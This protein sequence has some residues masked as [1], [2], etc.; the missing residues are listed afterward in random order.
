MNFFSKKKAPKKT[1]ETYDERSQKVLEGDDKEAE[2]MAE[3][4][5]DVMF[6]V[7]AIRQEALKLAL[8]GGDI[9]DIKKHLQVREIESTLPALKV[10]SANAS[11]ETV[12]ANGTA[13]P[14]DSLRQTQSYDGT[15]TLSGEVMTNGRANGADHVSELPDGPKRSSPG[16][17]SSPQPTE[18]AAPERPSLKTAVSEPG[19]SSSTGKQQ[20]P[21]PKNPNH[22]PWADEEEEYGKESE[23][24][25]SFE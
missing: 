23:V 3:E 13:A 20:A 15:R 21:Q 6:D 24:R 7:D 11:L 19:P 22:N 2:K 18:S 14:Q 10:E 16:P 12:T 17:S 5:S 25:M 9:E 1:W 4:N 8:E